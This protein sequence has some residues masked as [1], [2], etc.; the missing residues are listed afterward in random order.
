MEDYAQRRRGCKDR[1]QRFKEIMLLALRIEEGA[2]TKKGQNA[3]L[4][5]IKGKEIDYS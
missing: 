2:R 5:A 4:E 3:A 1:T